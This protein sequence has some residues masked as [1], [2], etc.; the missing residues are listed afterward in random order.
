MAFQIVRDYTDHKSYPEPNMNDKNIGVIIR[1]AIRE[2]DDDVHEN[3][4]NLIF[5]NVFDSDVSVSVVDG[6][7]AF[8]VPA[9]MT[10]FVLVAAIASVHTKGVT[11]TTDIQLRRR[12]TGA[13]VDM[14][15]TK[16]TIGDEY[17][18]ADS[19]INTSYDDVITGDQIY[20]DIDTIHSGTA[21]KG[22]AVTLTFQ[23]A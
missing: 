11:A 8:T 14:L 18:A 9:Y 15:S 7:K 17:F 22:L 13:D 21:P 3:T 10:T 5:F 4:K 12:R 23:E 1:R 2:I 6:K 20:V 19:V 16:I